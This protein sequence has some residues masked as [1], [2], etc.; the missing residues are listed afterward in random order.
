MTFVIC[1]NSSHC[2]YTAK[3]CVFYGLEMYYNFTCICI[4]VLITGIMGSRREQLT[5]FSYINASGFLFKSKHDSFIAI[6]NA[7]HHL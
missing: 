6:P 7:G 2:Q 5:A 4:C 1:T 3:S